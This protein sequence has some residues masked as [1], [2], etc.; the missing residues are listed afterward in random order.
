MII[1]T[2]PPCMKH[3]RQLLKMLRRD[4]VV[5]GVAVTFKN[6]LPHPLLLLRIHVPHSNDIENHH[7]FTLSN[8]CSL[9]T[10]T[11]LIITIATMSCILLTYMIR[12]YLT[13][14]RNRDSHLQQELAKALHLLSTKQLLVGGAT[15]CNHDNS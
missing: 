13:A 14:K 4:T 5:G 10:I 7:I 6:A 8:T 1:L 3:S 12:L 2:A 15:L 9:L 11:Q